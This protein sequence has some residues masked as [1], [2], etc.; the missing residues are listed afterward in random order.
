[1]SA[2]LFKVFYKPKE[3]LC[4][5]VNRYKLLK[6]EL[7][8]TVIDKWKVCV[9]EDLFDSSI[10]IDRGSF[11]DIYKVKFKDIDFILKEVYIAPYM[12]RKLGLTIGKE[13]EK[14]QYPPEAIIGFMTNNILESGEAPNFVYVLGSYFC[15]P[16]KVRSICYNL[17]MEEVQGNLKTLDKP[18]SNIVNSAV[19]QLLLGL[20]VLHK[21]YGLIHKDI[22]AENILI[23]RIH[24]T[25]CFRY[26]TTNRVFYVPNEGYIFMLADFGISSSI[27]SCYAFDAFLGTRNF[28]IESS[29]QSI[30]WGSEAGLEY[31]LKPFRVKLKPVFST[32]KYTVKNLIPNTL[33]NRWTDEKGNVLGDYTE[34]IMSADNLQPDL[35]IDLNDVDTFPAAEFTGDIQD[36][37]RTFAGGY[38]YFQPYFEH[39]GLGET[40]QK[41]KD[42]VTYRNCVDLQTTDGRALK[43]ISADV[44]TAFLFPEFKTTLT[45]V[46]DDF[47][48]SSYNT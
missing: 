25:G 46:I 33:I 6:L 36:I 43:Y 18:T 48:F 27:K 31:K 12:L 39:L 3:G 16:C 35:E 21:K 1:M 17:L 44:T 5:R 34:N 8:K 40:S 20:N 38:R 37:I 7:E 10:K 30:G 41:I 15:K 19:A 14:H 26:E 28:K 2:E 32:Y 29:G 22:K 4:D 24:S 11:G 23:K 13:W 45:A 9:N 47:K 42:L